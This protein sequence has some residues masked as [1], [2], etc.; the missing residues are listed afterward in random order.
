MY[1]I[2]HDQ[3]YMGH[4]VCKVFKKLFLALEK[5]LKL[6]KDFTSEIYTRQ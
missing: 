2:L 4:Y 5:K 3:F 6:L 1:D